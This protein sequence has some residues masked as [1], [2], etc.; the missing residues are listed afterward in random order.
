MCE[1]AGDLFV[2]L[3]LAIAGDLGYGRDSPLLCCLFGG[4]ILISLDYIV[5]CGLIA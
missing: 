2:T 5:L 3:T 1:N 4:G